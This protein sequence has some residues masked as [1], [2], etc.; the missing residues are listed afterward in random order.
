[1]KSTKLSDFT[2]KQLKLMLLLVN[3]RKRDLQGRVEI[4]HERTLIANLL[5]E[6]VKE[7]EAEIQELDLMATQ[8]AG[9]LV[10]IE[11]ERV[12]LSN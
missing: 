8:F 5:K 10:Q 11:H 2:E 7:D 1:M 6:N 12:A 3:E 4:I 9:A